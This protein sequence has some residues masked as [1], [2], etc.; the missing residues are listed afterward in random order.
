[1]HETLEHRLMEVICRHQKIL[2]SY[3]WFK[4]LEESA[5]KE[6]TMPRP[7]AVYEDLLTQILVLNYIS[8]ELT[9]SPYLLLIR[10]TSNTKLDTLWLC[11]VCAKT[12]I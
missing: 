12:T 1:M 9:F 8:Y 6:E 11:R 3:H 7:N 2:S 4:K 5:F 10:V